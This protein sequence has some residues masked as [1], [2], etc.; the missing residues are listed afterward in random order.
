MSAKE[1]FIPH[2]KIR[3]VLE[4]N[5]SADNLVQK[6]LQLS[7]TETVCLLDSC[8]V[9][10]L[11][12]HL[13]IAGIEPTEVSE[14]SGNDVQKILSSLDK[15][16]SNAP[17]NFFTLSYDLGLKLENILQREKEI[18]TFP[19]PDVFLASFDCLIV[20][21][22]ETGKTNISGEQHPAISIEQILAD[23]SA[24]SDF[25]KQISAETFVKSNFSKSE[26]ISKVEE[27]QELIRSGETYQTNL[28]Q[29]FRASIS[30]E[31][32]PQKIFWN[33]RKKHPSPFA[34]FIKRKNDF[35]ISISPER[36][37]KIETTKTSR[38]VKTSP[39]KGTRPR[40]KTVAEDDQLR[41]E[42]I[43]SKKDI[44]ENTMIVDLLRNDLGRICEFGSIT[45]E[46]L[47]DLE[48]HPSLFHLVS[49][50]KGN[51]RKNT[52]FSEI[53]EAIFPC[54]SITG[55]PKIRTMEIIDQLETVNRGLSMGAIGYKGLD[56]GFDLSVAIRTLVV[57]GNELI[58]N[59]GG[60]IV[61]DSDP[62]MEYEESLLKAKA[63]FKAI[64]AKT[65]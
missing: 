4:I 9:G 52:K 53:L 11:G 1:K 43:T 65:F 40:G 25:E 29:Q 34:A 37:V 61:I 35:V 56:N 19:E 2:V 63:I 5:I 46:K 45:V 42:L 6:L 48:K 28:T 32:T 41:N 16:L 18:S 36:F 24:E 20:H 7:E 23:V 3:F 26:Y 10:H 55:C 27:I 60:G 15:K 33:L 21:D 62:E 31:L 59:V 8:G 22:Y 39:I 30:K 13:L 14:V 47:C 57:R 54:G 64:E 51:L 38:E 50:I 44:A 58:F 17:A 49:T 12:S